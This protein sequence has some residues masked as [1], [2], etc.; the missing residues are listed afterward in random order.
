MKTVTVTASKTYDIHI[1][2]GLLPTL[3]TEAV[4]LGKA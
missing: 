2:R 3:G 4:K 1:G